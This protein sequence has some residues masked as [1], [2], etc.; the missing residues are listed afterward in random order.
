MARKSDLK[1]HLKRRQHILNL[2]KKKTMCTVTGGFEEL[3]TQMMHS[4]Q[5]QLVIHPFLRMTKAKVSTFLFKQLH[6]GAK[7]FV[8]FL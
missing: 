1:R 3:G 4:P 6:V 5:P 7:S 2:V 8:L